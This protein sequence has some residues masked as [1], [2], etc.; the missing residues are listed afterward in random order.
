EVQARSREVPRPSSTP[1]PVRA[2]GTGPVSGENP[3]RPDVPA[4]AAVEKRG[5]A[6]AGL[7]MVGAVVERHG[8]VAWLGAILVG[9]VAGMLWTLERASA[10]D[11]T[12][13]VTADRRG[14]KPAPP[15]PPPL[16]TGTVTPM[17]GPAAPAPAGSGRPE[18]P[19][20]AP[21]KA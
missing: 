8:W 4:T 13:P 20:P 5:W 18:A 6:E 12:P 14:G 21:R 7:G 3:A 9:T 1:E 17:K 11:Q 19:V 2:E 15:S 16:L 10:P